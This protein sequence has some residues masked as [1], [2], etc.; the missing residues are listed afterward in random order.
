MGGEKCLKNGKKDWWIKHK[1]IIIPLKLSYHTDIAKQSRFKIILRLFLDL[2][3]ASI[4]FPTCKLLH[5]KINLKFF[6][7]ILGILKTDW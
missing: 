6:D 1:S 3:Y 7:D 5:Q 4:I 2:S